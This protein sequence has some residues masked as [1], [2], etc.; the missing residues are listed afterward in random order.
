[1]EKIEANKPK[2]N[3]KK[4]IIISVIVIVILILGIGSVFAVKMI[5]EKIENDKIVVDNVPPTITLDEKEE[6]TLKIGK[7]YEWTNSEGGSEITL[8]KNNQVEETSWANLGGAMNYKGTYKIEGNKLTISIT[9]MQGFMEWEPMP[10]QAKKIFTYT[11]TDDN[12]FKDSEG[13]VYKM[14]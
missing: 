8:K 1:M 9:H 3:K 6:P 5:K 2:R 14:K 10:S 11:I 7:T 12:Q 13:R 4:I